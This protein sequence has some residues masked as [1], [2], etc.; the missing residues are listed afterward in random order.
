MSELS[1][2]GFLG[3]MMAA[4][5]APAIVRAQS[6]MKI[7]VPSDKIIITSNSLVPGD[8][9]IDFQMSGGHGDY[10]NETYP[11]GFEE[12]YRV[13]MPAPSALNPVRYQWQRLEDSGLWVTQQESSSPTITLDDPLVG[14]TR[15][16][17]QVTSHG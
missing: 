10:Y 13:D 15:Y 16:R 6:L 5:A 8:E 12:V 2:R 9:W 4:C 1:R 7:V 3:A 14:L 17:V 11:V